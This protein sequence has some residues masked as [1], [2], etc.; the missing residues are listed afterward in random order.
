M[1]RVSDIDGAFVRR[2]RALGASWGA[3]AR[4]AGCAETD[5]RRAHDPQ[6]AATV[7]AVIPRRAE[8]PRGVVRRRLLTAG[9]HPDEAVVISRL[10]HSNGAKLQSDVLARGIAGGGLATDVC[11][12][13]KKAG[14]RI[15][16]RFVK[17]A[18]AGFQLTGES[19]VAISDLAGLRG[20]P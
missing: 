9:L 20:R 13:A 18:G 15:G 17:I 5:L 6:F 4:M 14:E 3:I 7:S 10:W 11:R 8:N 16:L 1:T 2:K 19:V 12:D